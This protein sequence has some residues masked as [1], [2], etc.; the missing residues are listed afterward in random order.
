MKAARALSSPCRMGF[1]KRGAACL[2]ACTSGGGV[3][4]V[5]AWLYHGR[6]WCTQAE[7]M[8]L[9]NMLPSFYVAQT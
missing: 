8:P 7:N 4:R 1:G 2:V 3:G 6:T 9:L 5:T